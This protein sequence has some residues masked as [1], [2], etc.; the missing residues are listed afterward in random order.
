M[1]Y[2]Y[3]VFVNIGERIWQCNEI[4]KTDFLITDKSDVWYLLR[5]VWQ[6]NM[7]MCVGLNIACESCKQTQHLADEPLKRRRQ[8]QKMQFV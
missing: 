1:L 5:A 3:T 8:M 6:V 2:S 4:M 7:S